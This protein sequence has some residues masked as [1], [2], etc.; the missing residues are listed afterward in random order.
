MDIV[1][2][3]LKGEFLGDFIVVLPFILKPFNIKYIEFVLLL[4]IF[5]MV[6]L[7]ENIEESS[8]I[9]EK[10]A[11]PLDLTKLIFIL[12]FASHACACVWNYIGDIEVFF[13]YRHSYKPISRMSGL[14]DMVWNKLLGN[15]DTLSVSIGVQ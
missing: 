6:K 2:H 4:R 5:R 10:Y 13:L 3:Y 9:R 1:K 11:T 8:S 7:V 15:Q 12:I 14:R